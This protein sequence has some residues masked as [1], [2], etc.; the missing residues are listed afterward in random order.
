MAG[1]VCVE[2]L[3]ALVQL[4][5]G[6]PVRGAAAGG[7]GGGS[8]ALHRV[9][10]LTNKLSGAPTHHVIP[11]PCRGH[12][13]TILDQQMTESLNLTI[14]G[15]SPGSPWHRHYWEHCSSTC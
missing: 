14:R 6:H 8:G 10:P 11:L 4:Q 2:P 5:V 3:V 15:V 1:A 13:D 12:G 7:A 9:W